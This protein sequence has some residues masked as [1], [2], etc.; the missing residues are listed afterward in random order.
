MGWENEHPHE[1][2]LSNRLWFIPFF[3]RSKYGIPCPPLGPHDDRKILLKDLRIRPKSLFLYEYDFGDR[4]EHQILLEDILSNSNSA[5]PNHPVCLAGQGRCPPEDC[6]GIETYKGL[7]NAHADPADPYYKHARL[8]LGNRFNPNS[9][10]KSR[11]NGKLKSIDEAG[12]F[13]DLF[14]YP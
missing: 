4:W 12:S 10:S 2:T 8:L 1:F 13:A 5:A 9:F 11:I 6:G 14:A 3:G 7:V